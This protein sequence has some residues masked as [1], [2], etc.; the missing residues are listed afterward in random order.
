MNGDMEKKLNRRKRENR[1]WPRKRTLKVRNS[2]SGMRA[3]AGGVVAERVGFARFGPLKPVENRLGPPS[4]TLIFYEGPKTTNSRQGN[5]GNGV[6]SGGVLGTKA[7]AK[8]R[9]RRRPYLC[10]VGTKLCGKFHGFLRDFSRFIG[11][12]RRGQARIIAFYRSEPFLQMIAGVW[13]I[14]R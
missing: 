9:A 4:P 11:Y 5:E 7:A 10:A 13:R 8:R 2:D 14:L 12:F 3:E 1:D 6:W